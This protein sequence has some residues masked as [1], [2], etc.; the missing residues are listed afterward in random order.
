MLLCEVSLILFG[1]LSHPRTGC[2]TDSYAEIVRMCLPHLCWHLIVLE[3][4]LQW[5]YELLVCG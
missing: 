3:E 1:V 5:I 2:T 4:V